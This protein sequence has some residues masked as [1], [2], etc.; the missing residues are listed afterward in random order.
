M[1]KYKLIAF[2][3]MEEP[4]A[5][6]DTAPRWDRTPAGSPTP[7]TRGN[8]V[9]SD[10]SWIQA[11]PEPPAE[12]ELP[13]AYTPPAQQNAGLP[14]AFRRDQP[15]VLRTIGQATLFKFRTVPHVL[16]MAVAIIGSILNSVA[17]LLHKVDSEKFALILGTHLSILHL[18]HSI[19]SGLKQRGIISNRMANG[20]SKLLVA[21]NFA[22]TTMLTLSCFG[23][24]GSSRRQG[25]L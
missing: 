4:A 3:H 12:G 18:M 16:S 17:L 20:L 9:P 11:P 10:D 8:A 22:L 2:E 25:R 5:A 6:A 21:T 24:I 14:A 1:S 13:P 19:L 23:I 7:S 15:S